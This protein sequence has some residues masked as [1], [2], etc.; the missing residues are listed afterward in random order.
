MTSDNAIRTGDALIALRALPAAIADT[1]ITSPPYY[2][3]RDYGIEGQIGLEDSPEEYIENLVAV[4][5][6][7]RRAL[8]DDGTLWVVIG[9]TY[10][11]SGKRGGRDPTIGLRNL[12]NSEYPAKS[13]P[14]G[15]KPKDLIGIPWMLA[16]ALRADGWYL[17]QDIIWQKPNPMPESVADRCTKSHEYIFML[18]KS[19]RYYYYAEAI[20]EPAVSTSIKKFTDKSTDKQRG[21]G[22]RHAGFNGRYAERLAV[23]GVPTTRNKR[24]VWAVATH[25]YKA[26]HF[27]TYPP[28]LIRP[29]VLAGSRPGGI[30]LDP[31]FG[32]GTTGLVALQEGRRYIGIELNSEYCAIAQERLEAYEQSKEK[33]VV[34]I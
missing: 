27:A 2:C 12:G 15:C 4:F 9:D 20:K 24:D 16:F 6:E 25:P 34:S 17:R 28:E 23:E 1:C 7:V 11:G 29:C 13:I 31:F 10:A 26:A 33:D 5:C 30:V 8:K 32:A 14:A 19:P 22:R 21:H 18:S 3:L